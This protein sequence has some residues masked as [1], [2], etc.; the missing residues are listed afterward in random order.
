MLHELDQ[1]SQKPVAVPEYI[2]LRRQLGYLAQFLLWRHVGQCTWCI[3]LPVTPNQQPSHRHVE[4]AYWD[5]PL[6]VIST[7][8]PFTRYLL[9][10]R[11][12]IF[13]TWHVSSCNSTLADLM[14]ICTIC[15]HGYNQNS[16]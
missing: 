1:P 2:D 10:P 4:I 8:P 11:S 16:V 7:N 15:R 12:A 6:S 14:S 9:M 3:T 5:A 13:A